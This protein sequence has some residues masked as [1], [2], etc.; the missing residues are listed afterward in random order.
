MM[1][2]SITFRVDK[3]QLSYSQLQKS[4]VVIIR[5]SFSTKGL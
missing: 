3:A 5:T 2:V 1:E 4:Q